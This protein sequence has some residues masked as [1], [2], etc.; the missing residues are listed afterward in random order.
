MSSGVPADD[1]SRAE[2]AMEM[3]ALVGV[4]PRPGHARRSAADR[5]GLAD[6]ESLKLDPRCQPSDELMLK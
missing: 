1:I 3:P 4:V 2:V 6:E 5:R